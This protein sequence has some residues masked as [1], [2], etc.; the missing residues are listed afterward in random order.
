M[1]RLEFLEILKKRLN[2]I[3]KADL[4]ETLDYY[5][6]IL[7]DKIDDGMSEADAINSLGSIDDIVNTTLKEIS[8]PKLIKEKLGLNK[9][10][11]SWQI[12][13]LASTFYIWIPVIIALIAVA[14]ALYAVLWSGV[15]VVCAVGVSSLVCA[16]VMLIWGLIDIFAGS[17]SSGVLF[18]GFSLLFLGVALL[19]GVLTKHFAKLMIEVCK[20]LVIKIKSLFIRRGELDE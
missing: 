14:F 2:G 3:P 13:L 6:E 1:T 18:I 19:F 11:K 12:I 7:S 8:F 17:V 20:K 15:I 5:N 4:E 9:K 10:I 16:P